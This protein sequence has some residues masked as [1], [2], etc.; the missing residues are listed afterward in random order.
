MRNTIQL[1]IQY[2]IHFALDVR[3]AVCEAFSFASTNNE[4]NVIR[5][6]PG[7][8][9]YPW[10]AQDADG[11]IYVYKEAPVPAGGNQWMIS[12]NG[13][14]F[15]EISHAPGHY[16]LHEGETNDN[17]EMH[18]IDRRTSGYMIIDGILLPLYR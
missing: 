8:I 17:W 3:D 4:P 9:E 2:F 12:G 14:Q 6:E 7:E 16:F 1:L 5:V 10:V 18:C 15:Q 11:A 13:T